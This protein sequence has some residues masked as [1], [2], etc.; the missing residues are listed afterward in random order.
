MYT[1]KKN[2]WNHY[3]NNIFK[4]GNY[5]SYGTATGARRVTLQFLHTSY[6]LIRLYGINDSI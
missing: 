6:T 1:I 2:K 5:T 4:N 3:K